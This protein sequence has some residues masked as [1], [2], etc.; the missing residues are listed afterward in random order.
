MGLRSK[1]HVWI[2]GA[3]FAI[4][5]LRHDFERKDGFAPSQPRDAKG[6]WSDGSRGSGG[7]GIGAGIGA[8]GEG[9]G[10][11]DLGADDPG[12]GDV[13][14]RD[15]DWADLDFVDDTGEKFRTIDAVRTGEASWS[16]AVSD[17]RFDGS[18]AQEMVFDR[19]GSIIPS[20]YAAPGDDLGWDE[21]HSVVTSGGDRIRFERSDYR[22]TIYDVNTG[23]MLGRS[24]WGRNRS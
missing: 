16:T 9:T 19:D 1:F 5:R 4:A 12:L 21:R 14:L 2:A 10:L 18:L 17:R 13:D 20:E 22:Q 3:K 6:R 24:A 11:G 23:A 7:G 15:F 8:G